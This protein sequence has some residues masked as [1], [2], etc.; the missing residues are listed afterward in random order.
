MMAHVP[1]DSTSPRS[2]AGAWV[3]GIAAAL[4]MGITLVL[5]L[6]V[7]A[8]FWIPLLF[9]AAIAML[10]VWSAR[11]RRQ[12]SEHRNESDVKDPLHASRRWPTERAVDDR[13]PEQ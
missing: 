6:G 12:I 10:S 11:R 2:R 5:S 8:I 3:A 13:L 4:A 9:M 1:S 7:A